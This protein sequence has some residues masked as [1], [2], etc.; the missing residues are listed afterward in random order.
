MMDRS[1]HPLSTDDTVAATYLQAVENLLRAGPRLVDGFRDALRQDPD[2][3][4]AKIGEAR[5]L[6]IYGDG[7][8]ARAAAADAVRLAASATPREQQHVQALALA[9]NGKSHEA[10]I[11]IRRHVQDYP[12]DAMVLQP[13]LSAFGI[14]GFSGRID[15]ARELLELVDALAPYYDDDW[16][17]SSVRAYAEVDGGRVDD[18][19]SRVL[20]SLE[21]MPSNANAAHVRSHVYYEKNQHD[22]AAAF[23]KR[24]LNDNAKEVL[25]RG[26][27]AWHLALTELG[28]GN[29]QAAWAIFDEEIVGPLR[30]TSASTVPPLNILTD[31]ASFLWRAEL[32]GEAKANDDWRLLAELAKSR[33]PS[34]G[35]AYADIHSAMAFAQ[36]DDAQAMGKLRSDLA[37]IVAAVPAAGVAA[38]MC[39]AIHAYRARQWREVVAALRP[40]M[41][42]TVRLG[43][44]HAQLDI[45][46]RT[47]LKA[48]QML[49][50][51]EPLSVM[52]RE[53]PQ[54]LAAA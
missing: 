37:A 50:D 33:F 20:L 54:L 14:I 7:A 41:A 46:D 2:F 48:L 42:E 12:T 47:M 32:L 28:L 27:L 22:A 43:G 1:K 26:H 35:L 4:L 25:L 51:A 31:C 36:T 6:A 29:R 30:G 3:A 15:R 38:A 24:W 10:L 45:V 17:F 23:L 5:A 52:T 16:W 13:A 18:A 39:A 49:D 11:A 9:V 34:A 8:S 53:R 44:S 21:A 19:E 40:V